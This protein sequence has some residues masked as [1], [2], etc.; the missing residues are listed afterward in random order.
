MLR[1]S[2][3]R[4]RG[5]DAVHEFAIPGRGESYDLWEDRRAAISADAVTRFTPPIVGRNAETL[6]RGILVDELADLL[7]QS[8]APN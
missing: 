1:A 3:I 4:S 2:L 8:E 7:R 5:G 6:D